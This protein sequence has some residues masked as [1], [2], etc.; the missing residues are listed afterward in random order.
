[1]VL[2]SYTLL[3][4]SGKNRLRLDIRLQDTAAGETIAE[5]ALTGSEE[6]LFELASQAG[7]RLRQSLGVTSIS[8]VTSESVRASLPATQQAFRLYT[9]GQSKVWAFDFVPARD[10][11]VKAAAADPGYPLAHSALSEVWNRLGYAAKARAEAQRALELS[12][13]L[14]QEN[15]LLIEGLYR[16]TISDWP[17]SIEAYKKL[18]NLF[19]DNLNYGLR[20]ASAELHVSPEDSLRTLAALRRLPSP[21]GDDARVDLGEASVLASRDL[22]KARAAAERAAEKGTAQGSHLLVA[23]SYGFLCQQGAAAG[24]LMSESIADCERA[25]QSYA[26]AGEF[27]NE[28]RTLS[29]FAGIYFQQ[30]D[31]HRAES[32]WR[33]AGKE[34]RQV[35]D[36]EGVAASANNLGDALFLQGDL[37]GAKTLLEGAILNYQKIEDKDGVALA[38]ND[39]GGLSREK[40]DLKIAE[41]TYQQAKATAQ[42]IDDKNAIAYV[43]MGLGDVMSDR[44]DLA[45]SRKSYE[46]SLA[47]RQQIGERQGVAET[48]IALAELSIEEGRAAS[49]ESLMRQCEAQFRR[50]NQVDDELSASVALTEVLLAQGRQAD[51]AQ[52]IRASEPL[53]KMSQNRLTRFQFFLTSSRVSLASGQPR[54]SGPMLNQL[55]SDA[56]QKG[57]TV[58][59]LKTRLALAQLED[60]SGKTEAAQTH[61]LA[62]ERTARAKGLNLIAQKAA[63]SREQI[64]EHKENS[65]LPVPAKNKPPS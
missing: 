4:G 21:V 36:I 11:L 16:D 35:G 43:F 44:G 57:F 22:T 26:A 7:V 29:D 12:G 50:E 37:A 3:P 51:A 55:L 45:A 30:G 41:T 14:S 31:V 33:E 19:P 18:F 49:A 34:F 23:R 13:P 9:E 53:A 25:R 32:M 10:L 20:L 42:E 6:G 59:E 62:L 61:L 2:G 48:E 24:A 58:I 8:P 38:L 46:D 52:E 56:H 15:R 47:L 1:V 64:S 39:L 54:L 17:K 65:A 60:K 5:D 63:A 28:A 27:N 40:G